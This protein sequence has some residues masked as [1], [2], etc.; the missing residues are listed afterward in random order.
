VALENQPVF[1]A[2]SI[3]KMGKS[4]ISSSIF[5]REKTGDKPK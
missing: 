4:K 2:P 3:P 5:S 1:Q